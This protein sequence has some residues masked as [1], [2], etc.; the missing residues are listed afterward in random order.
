MSDCVR[1]T[2]RQPI[3]IILSDFHIFYTKNWDCITYTKV[4]MDTFVDRAMNSVI[5]ILIGVGV[6]AEV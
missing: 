5:K 1:K 2:L 3:V 6:K 4:T